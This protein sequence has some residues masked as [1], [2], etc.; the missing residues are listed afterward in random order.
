MDAEGLCGVY[1]AIVT[2]FTADDR[3]DEA[4]LA[5]VIV[6]FATTRSPVLPVDSAAE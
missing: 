6:C 4:A 2:P 1:P 3:M 5:K